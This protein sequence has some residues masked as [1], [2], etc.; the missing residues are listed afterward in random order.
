MRL[1]VQDR[2]LR[3]ALA[4]MAAAG[5]NLRPVFSAISNELAAETGRAFAQEGYPEKWKKLAA[6]TIKARSRKGKRPGQVLQMSGSMAS[7]VQ[8][9][10]TS[11][12][13]KLTVGKKYAAIQQLGGKAGRGKRIIIPPRPYLPLVS[14]SPP[15]DRNPKV[16]L[17]EPASRIVLRL[18]RRHFGAT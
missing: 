18:M 11:S 17:N 14:K 13:A 16:E 2:E 1:E 8:A 9:S 10:S 4:R 3:A 5:R 6:A 15:G 7:S 12:E